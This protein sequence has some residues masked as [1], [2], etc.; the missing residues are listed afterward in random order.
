[1]PGSCATEFCSVTDLPGTVGIPTSG[2]CPVGTWSLEKMPGAALARELREELGIDI[3]APSGP[4][5]QEVRGDT[6][7]A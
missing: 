4:H 2:T 7:G 3:A 5:V 6:Y 1:V